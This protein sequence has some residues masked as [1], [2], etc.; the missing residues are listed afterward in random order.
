MC[1]LKRTFFIAIRSPILRF[2]FRCSDKHSEISVFSVI[3]C[4]PLEITRGPVNS[5]QVNPV[6]YMY[7]VHWVN[8]SSRVLV[9]TCTRPQRSDTTQQTRHST[10]AVSMLASIAVVGTTLKQYWVNT[11]CLL[12]GLHHISTDL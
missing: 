1:L 11:S 2:L 8:K 12:G 9:C 4:Q 7:T 3:P 6:N 5:V 10:N